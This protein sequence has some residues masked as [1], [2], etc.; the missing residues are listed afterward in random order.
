MVKVVQNRGQ[1]EWDDKDK[2]IQFILILKILIVH[3]QVG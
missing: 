2:G 1:L 3:Y